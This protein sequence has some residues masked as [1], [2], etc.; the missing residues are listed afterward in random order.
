MSHPARALIVIPVYNE[1]A[2][3]PALLNEIASV[4]KGGAGGGFTIEF[5]LVDDGSSKEEWARTFALV[6]AGGLKGSLPCLHLEVN[7]GKGLAL[8]MGFERALAEG[9]DYAGFL[10]ADASTSVAELRRA[11]D[12]FA[13]RSGTPL[14]AVI[15]SRVA[16]LGRNVARNAARHYLGRVFATFVS[17]LFGARIYDS[18]CGMKLFRASALKRHLDAPTDFR[19][20]WDT[21]LVLSML[22]AG[23][24]VHEFPVD[25]RETGGSK[26]SFPRD[27]L[28]MALRLILF[29]F[30]ARD[31][32]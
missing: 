7:G 25:W 12:Y 1:S 11:M 5:L 22:A 17:M 16:L 31:G 28:I 23:E 9:Y 27:P 26:L 21:E 18:Q 24:S 32:S 8:K 3:L 2:R 19:W 14:A 15:G 4:R 6:E 30:R 29:R 20:V 13:A 10:D